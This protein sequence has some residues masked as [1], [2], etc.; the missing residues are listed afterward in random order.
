MR[1]RLRF[2]VSISV[3]LL[4]TQVASP[5]ASFP[6]LAGRN[7]D[8]G[9]ESPCGESI[10]KQMPANISA[11]KMIETVI[12]EMLI[13]SPT[14]RK[15]CQKIARLPRLRIRIVLISNLAGKFYRALSYVKKHD[16]GLVSVKIKI[17]FPDNPVEI[18]GHEFEHIVEQIEDINLHALASS[19]SIDVQ[20][21]RDGTFE[22]DRAMAAGRRV[23]KEYQYNGRSGEKDCFNMNNQRW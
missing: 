11:P 5:A 13:V 20:R 6:F 1:C 17:F 2:M 16:D 8:K 21:H 18:I 23:L 15:Q 4:L 12:K 14:F 7:D 9:I 10:S 22:T 3:L 19:K